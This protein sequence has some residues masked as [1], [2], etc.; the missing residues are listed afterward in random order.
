MHTCQTVLCYD[1]RECR[2]NPTKNNLDI[3][4][5]SYDGAEVRDLLI[6]NEITRIISPINIGCRNN[7]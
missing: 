5:G 4:M 7:P 2:K 1:N 6:L 3:A